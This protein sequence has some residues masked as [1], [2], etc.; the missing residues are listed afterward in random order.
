[1]W[2]V[3]Q[4]APAPA[5]LWLDGSEKIYKLLNIFDK[6]WILGSCAGF[7]QQAFKRLFPAIQ[8]TAKSKKLNDR[9]QAAKKLSSSKKWTVREKGLPDG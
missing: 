6:F 8:L 1:M 5:A 9:N 3:D 2:P 4:R 7:P